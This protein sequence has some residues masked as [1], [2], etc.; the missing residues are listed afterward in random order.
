[1]NTPRYKYTNPIVVRLYRSQKDSLNELMNDR[2]FCQKN[3]IH[4]S[5]DVFRMSLN[6]TLRKFEHNKFRRE[7]SS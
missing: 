7:V 3:N 4:S 1:M 2:D 6:E 5:S